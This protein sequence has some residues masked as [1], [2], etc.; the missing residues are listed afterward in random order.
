MI[1]K[2]GAYVFDINI[3]A[4]TNYYKANSLCQ[5]PACK[6]F[7]A[8]AKNTFPSLTQF[9]SE[10]GVDISRPDEL[11]THSINGKIYYQFVAYTVVGKIVESDKQKIDITDGNLLFNIV[12]D[13]TYIPNEQ[14]TKEIFTV[15]A[16]GIELP[17]ELNKL[18]PEKT[19]K[20][21][22]IN[23]IKCLFKKENQNIIAL[24]I[25]PWN[26]IVE[27]MYDKNLDTFT[28]EVIQAI[29]SKDRAMRYVILKDE[30]GLFTYC[31]EAI[32]QFDEDEWKYIFSNKEFLPAM[33]ESPY[34]T[35]NNSIFA[36]KE[37][38]L[39]EIYAEPQYKQYFI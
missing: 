4:T 26:K 22:I 16:Y 25:S 28:D 18:C 17:W 24:T 3:E 27:T 37:D 6:N 1:I 11:S 9:L 8:Q 13:N 5:C 29:Y 35:V 31:F 30:K 23:K 21:S 12:I 10:F 33:W 39:K 14:S 7:Y 19:P 2:K 15:T 34:G 38:A 32:Y 20:K 36:T